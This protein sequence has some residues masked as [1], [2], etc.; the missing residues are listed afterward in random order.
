MLMTAHSCLER[1]SIGG[2]FTVDPVAV[3]Y[4]HIDLDVLDDI[5]PVCYP[6]P[7]GLSEQELIETAA[8][9]AAGHEVVGLDITEYRPSEPRDE[10]MLS[11][12]VPRL[13]QLCATA[14]S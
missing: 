14:A 6:E 4:L 12:L 7:G 13:V 10:Q 9:L 5:A 2:I 1:V 11:R 3:L 8:A